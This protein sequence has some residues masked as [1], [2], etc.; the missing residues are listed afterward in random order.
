MPSSV[1][2]ATPAT[3]VKP[4]PPSPKPVPCSP[5][6]PTSSSSTPSSPM[7]VASTSSPFFHLVQYIS[8][9]LPGLLGALT[10]DTIAAS[11]L[12]L[13]AAMRAAA[14][15]RRNRAQ[16][17]TLPAPDTRII[18]ACLLFLLA[19]IAALIFHQRH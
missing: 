12:A 1:S 10:A 11:A 13:A 5:G 7:A 2:S 15:A 3:H 14:S 4:P 17:I 19:Y 16:P 9:S 18:T 6:S 8:V